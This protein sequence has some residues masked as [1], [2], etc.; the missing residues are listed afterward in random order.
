MMGTMK[1]ISLALVF[2]F[3]AGFCFAQQVSFQIV[4]H[5]DTAD[6]V[7]EAS[8]TVEDQLVEMF[9]ENGYIV[10]NSPTVSAHSDSEANKL[11][12]SGLKE[13]KDGYSNYFVQINLYYTAEKLSPNGKAILKKAD[14]SLVYAKTGESKAKNTVKS[15]ES[16]DVNKDLY[17]LSADIFNE[18]KKAIKA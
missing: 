11:W 10:T 17:L 3:F 16:T 5:D 1:K 4:Q 7:T 18:I 15:K 6:E 8:Y 13:A 9:F 2:M 12:K 14:W